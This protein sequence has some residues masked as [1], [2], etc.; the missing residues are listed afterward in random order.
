MTNIQTRT[1]VQACV[2]ILIAALDIATPAE[3]R[4]A[5]KACEQKGKDLSVR[6]EERRANKQM[7]KLLRAQLS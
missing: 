7:A 4:D 6:M 1:G 5:I 3:I 2:E